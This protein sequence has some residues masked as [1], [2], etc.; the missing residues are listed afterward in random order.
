MFRHLIFANELRAASSSLIELALEAPESKDAPDRV[1]GSVIFADAASVRRL[2]RSTSIFSSSS[3][4]CCTCTS[5]SLSTPP[6]PA[7]R[8][9]LCSS[10]A[11]ARVRPL[12]PEEPLAIQLSAVPLSDCHFERRCFCLRWAFRRDA[13]RD[14]TL[15][16]QIASIWGLT[17]HPRIPTPRSMWM[18]PRTVKGAADALGTLLL[19]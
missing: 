10:L 19:S 5:S 3:S 2:C 17:P 9:H 1:C 8:A 11:S 15:I 7:N 18:Q 13:C 12:Q 4:S 6:P 16:V 14:A